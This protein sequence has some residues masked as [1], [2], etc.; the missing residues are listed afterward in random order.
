MVFWSGGTQV[1]KIGGPTFEI[2]YFYIANFIAMKVMLLNV[3]FNYV[4]TISSVYKY[5]IGNSQV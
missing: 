5:I 1:K 4:F 2:V 3:N